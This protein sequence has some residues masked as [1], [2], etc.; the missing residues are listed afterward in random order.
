MLHQR[1]NDDVGCRNN[2]HSPSYQVQAYWY[3]EDALTNLGLQ[4][5]VMLIPEVVDRQG[6]PQNRYYRAAK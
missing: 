6:S 2:S 4:K 5:H 1:L 3:A